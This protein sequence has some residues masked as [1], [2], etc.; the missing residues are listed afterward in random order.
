MVELDKLRLMDM[1]GYLYW[2]SSGKPYRKRYADE[3]IG[4]KTSNIW[5]DVCSFKKSE[6]LGYPT[7]KP[8]VLLNRILI[9]SC[10]KGGCI[11]DPFCGSGVSIYSAIENDLNWIGCDSSYVSIELIKKHLEFVYNLKAHDDYILINGRFEN[12]KKLLC[13]ML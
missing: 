10:P 5:D 6:R 13:K 8:L 3:F 2:S 12:S 1:S 4:V 11:L 9:S 7:Q